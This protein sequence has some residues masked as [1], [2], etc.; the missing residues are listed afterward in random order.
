VVVLLHCGHSLPALPFI[1][2]VLSF[3]AAFISFLREFALAS[4]RIRKGSR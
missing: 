3:V 1:L 4:V 2:A